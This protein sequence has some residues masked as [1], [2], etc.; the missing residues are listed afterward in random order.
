MGDWR[1]AMSWALIGLL[2]EAF[3]AR[4]RKVLPW[5]IATCSTTGP[6]AT[7]GNR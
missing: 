1:C 4:G 5:F 7:A 2:K 6:K 3:K